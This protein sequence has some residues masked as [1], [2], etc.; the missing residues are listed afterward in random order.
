MTFP[1]F[2]TTLRQAHEQA[3]KGPWE[4]FGGGN[5]HAIRQI[6]SGWDRVIGCDIDRR[7]PDSGLDRYDGGVWKMQDAHA[8]AL[9]RNTSPQ[10][11]AIMEVARKALARISNPLAAL[12]NDALEA[13]NKLNGPMALQIASDPEYLKSLATAALASIDALAAKTP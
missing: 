7:K 4:Y 3:T 8:I 12:Q 6:G 5:T 13:G 9:W 10:T 11:I 2:I 1:E